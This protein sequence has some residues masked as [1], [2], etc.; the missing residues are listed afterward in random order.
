MAHRHLRVARAPHRLDVARGVARRK[1]GGVLTI[2]VFIR[3]GRMAL[4]RTWFG[5]NSTAV[6][7]VIW[8]IA[9]LVVA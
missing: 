3:P 8:F 6:V 1:A 4:T 9:A 2:G 5:A 7:R